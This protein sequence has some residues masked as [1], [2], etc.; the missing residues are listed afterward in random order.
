[1]NKLLLPFLLIIIVTG[2]CITA[3]SKA[4]KPVD[5]P[6][7]IVFKADPNKIT[8]GTK[9]TLY[10]QVT[11]ASSVS[12][13]QGIGLVGFKG[14]MQV[15]PGSTVTYTL[16]A[17][18][19]Y[20]DTTAAVQVSVTEK[21]VEIKHTTFNLPVVSVFS[22]QPS[23]IMIGDSAVMTWDVQN[24]FDVAIDPGFSIIPPKGSREISPVIPTT[25]T[26]TATNGDGSII[27]A[28]TL[29]VSSTKPDMYTPKISFFKAD[30][31]VIKKGESSELS[32]ESSDASSATINKGI[33]TVDGSGKITVT[34]DKTTVYMLTVTDPRGAQYQS[35]AVNVK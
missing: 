22:I 31:Y 5:S 6:S 29:T 18:N 9:T 34:P 27:A 23:N 8:Q 1:M 15:A 19:A 33:G 12:I 35:V 30:P 10:W 28:T 25:Y 26:I 3:P 16:S 2:A 21:A 13:N 7:I 32:W 17:S 4:A 20:G 11:G 24:S 14:N